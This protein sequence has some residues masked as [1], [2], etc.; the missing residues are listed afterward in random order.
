MYMYLFYANQ[1]MIYFMTN[2]LFYVFLF[3][4]NK[5][6]NTKPNKIVWVLTVCL[7]LQAIFSLKKKKKN[8][9]KQVSE[10]ILMLCPTNENYFYLLGE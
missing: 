9:P 7:M 4:L 3:D 10:I 2:S 8:Q 6:I 5:K 1:Y